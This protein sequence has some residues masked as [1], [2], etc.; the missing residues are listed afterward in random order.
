MKFS[1]SWL[2][3]HLDLPSDTTLDALVDAMTMAGL[4]VE[5][6]D[7]PAAR[8]AAFTVAR[9]ITAEP[10]PDADKLRVCQVETI[11]GEKQIVCGAPNARAG[12]VGVYA[13]LGAFIP[14]LDFALDK[15]PRKI[16]GVESHGMLCS[17]KE[18]EAGDDHDGII[19]LT[20]PWE[21]GA[22]AAAALG[23]DDPVIDFEVTPNRP[24]WLGVHGVAR[25]L[26][27]SGLG[28]LRGDL[29]GRAA[30]VAPASGVNAPPRVRLEAP[31][32]CPVFGVR[33]LAGL[34]DGP[35]PDWMQARLRAAGVKPKSMLVDVT[36]Y[37]S[38]D[39][40][41][42]LHA[43]DAA[44]LTGDL[45]VRLAKPGETLAALDGETY[46]LTGEECVIADDTGVISLG[47]V[48]G[49]A[50]TAVGPDTTEIVLESA[51]FEP[52]RTARIGRAL[53]IASDAQYRFA[54]GVDPAS[55]EDGLERA[56]G[57]ILEACGGKAGAI[58][59]AGAAPT[60]NPAF[61]FDP[62]QV[63]R[64][65]GLK[66]SSDEIADLLRRLGCAVTPS[67]KML[68]VA[69]PSW[70]P[71]L[72]MSAD[73]V[74]EAARL[75][76]YDA[77]PVTSLPRR[78]G[79]RAPAV[80]A[81]MNRAFAARRAAATLGLREAVTWAFCRADQAAAFGA[82]DAPRLAN[83]I[84]SELDVMRP[85]PLPLLLL[86]L[87]RNRDRGHA[88]SALFEVG[89]AYSGLAP[90]DQETVAAGVRA[91]ATSRHW[92][93][94]EAVDV[95]TAKADALA[96]L[97]AAGV[98]VDKL[99]VAAPADP[100]WHPGR[101]GMLQLGPKLRLGVFG[102]LHPG[103]LAKL[104]V[105]GPVVGFEV[106]LDRIPTPRAKAGPARPALEALDLMALRRDFAFVVDAD[107]PAG[108]IVRAAAGADA[109]LISHVAVFD[110][111]AG[112]GLGA[113]NKS[114]GVEVTLQPRERTLDEA[115][116]EAVCSK[117]VAAVGKAT[118]ASLRA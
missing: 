72:G 39:R 66:A 73:L 68:N 28:K 15:K 64:L 83:P 38:L 99:G 113:G 97:S 58:E 49:G 42:P 88:D 91:A 4:E 114:V 9:V 92:A 56:T 2:A 13:P 24:D 8:L 5:D 106:Y 60:P 86:A 34:G 36:N 10:H 12:L 96:V 94:G 35:S 74:E 3:A 116:I 33:R 29:V 6:V 82:P 89:G 25:D 95:F 100:W 41:R 115:A 110:V 61:D 57:L 65:T 30:P 70:R 109:A 78:T 22:P 84:S 51:W 17:A 43:F 77:L 31:E 44:K 76:G 7:N 103:V 50:S 26:A 90:E 117:I 112:P 63:K 40:A 53:G 47:G 37:V 23:V 118:G 79:R 71:D 1:L 52:N 67:G 81:Q 55:L 18:L 62:A 48:M 87:Q 69:A 107:V 108:D 27:A 59:I 14:G 102:E 16:R 105:D 32:A 11:D 45:V 98:T 104:D 20:G 46:T 75:I 19:D 93:G 80:T 85:S 101:S 54:R 21:V 111:F